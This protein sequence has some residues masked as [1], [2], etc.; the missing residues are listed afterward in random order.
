MHLAKNLTAIIGGKQPAKYSGPP[1]NMQILSLGRAAGTCTTPM[2]DCGC[3][4][5]SMKSANL[6]TT[7]TKK[8]F[9]K[10]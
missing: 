10:K 8:E 4:V 3:L 2:G 6:F 1:S 5:V 7:D 9:M